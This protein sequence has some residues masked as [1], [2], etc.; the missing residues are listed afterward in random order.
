MATEI[1]TT[2]DLQQFRIQLLED[3]KLLFKRLQRKSHEEMAK[4]IR[5]DDHVEYYQEYLKNVSNNR[6]ALWEENWRNLLLCIS[7]N[8]DLL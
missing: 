7:R 1:I 5:G 6:G 4:I 8:Q 2:E 3:F